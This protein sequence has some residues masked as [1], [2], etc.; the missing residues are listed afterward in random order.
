MAVAS[1]GRKFPRLS[2]LSF[3]LCSPSSCANNAITA[4]GILMDII[5][6][7]FGVSDVLNCLWV[8]LLVHQTTSA[9]YGADSLSEPTQ[10]V[11]SGTAAPPRGGQDD[12]RA[13]S[14]VCN[15]SSFHTDLGA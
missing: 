11:L 14:P 6:G 5:E 1:Q 12:I 9:T 7:Q 13:T 2:S 3:F 8:Q 10:S 4:N 15:N